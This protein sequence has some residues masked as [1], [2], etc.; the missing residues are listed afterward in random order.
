MKRENVLWITRVFL[1][2]LQGLCI[3]GLAFLLYDIVAKLIMPDHSFVR[4]QWYMEQNQGSNADYPAQSEASYFTNW[5]QISLQLVFML[6]IWRQ[7]SKVL[8]SLHH[9]KTFLE[10]NERHFIKIRNWLF[11]L[12]LLDIGHFF[13]AQGESAHLE[14]QF[15]L[16]LL[17]FAFGAQILALVFAEGRHLAEEQKL[18]V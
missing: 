5:F 7:L 1:V 6:L 16:S 10:A 4:W 15:D 17:L 9:L 18:I 3:L 14:W 11:L 13:Q 2:I 12:W 8:K